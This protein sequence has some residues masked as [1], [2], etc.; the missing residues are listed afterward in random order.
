MILKYAY[1]IIRCSKVISDSPPI[2]HGV[3]QKAVGG[4]GNGNPLQYLC[5]ENPMD[6]GAWQATVHGVTLSQ[7]LLSY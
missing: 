1:S 6:R 2:K 4:V 7:T 3:V 5:L